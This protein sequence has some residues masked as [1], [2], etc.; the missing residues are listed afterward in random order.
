MPS[1]LACHAAPGDRS[2]QMT[3]PA[4]R[5]LI[6]DIESCTAC[7]L[8]ATRTRPVVG[9]GDGASGLLIV[10][11]APGAQEDATG[12]PFVGHS[13]TLLRRIVAEELGLNEPDLTITNVVRCRPPANRTPTRKEQAT[14]WPFME[15]QLDFLSPTVIL[16]VGNTA[17]QALLGTREG[18][19]TLRGSVYVRDGRVIV[20]TFHPA[21]A[22]RGRPDIEAALRSDVRRAGPYLE[23][24]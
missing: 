7:A 14:C 8:H 17:A 13:G 21:A 3:V 19:T 24:R 18:I 12:V 5:A 16:A 15:R 11:E 1:A 22:L 10:G 2:A 20:P 9:I 23:P 6:R 4:P